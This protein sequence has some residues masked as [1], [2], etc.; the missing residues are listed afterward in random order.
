VEGQGIALKSI[1]DVQDD[2]AEGRLVELL[3]DFAVPDNSL[4]LVYPTAQ[5]LPKRTRALIEAIAQA[6]G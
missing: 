4:Q 3:R 1:W 2:L 6:L 5:S